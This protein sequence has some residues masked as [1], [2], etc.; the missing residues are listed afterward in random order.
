MEPRWTEEQQNAL[1]DMGTNIIVSAGAGS[2]KTTV[3]TERVIRKLKKG[4][5]INKLL[6]LTFTDAASQ[7]MKERIRSAIKKEES[8]TKQLDLLTTAYICTF[9]SFSLSMVRKYHYLLNIDSDVNIMDNNIN[10]LEIKKIIDD[11][12]NEKYEAKDENFQKLIYQWCVKDDD[13]VKNGILSLYQKID[14]LVEKDEYLDNYFNTQFNKEVLDKKY[15]KFESVIKANIKNFINILDQMI[16]YMKP[17]DYDKYL[18]TRNLMDSIILGYE[19][20]DKFNE[21]IEIPRIYDA[22]EDVKN[23]KKKL[24]TLKKK[25]IS[26]YNDESKEEK[27]NHLLETVDNQKVIINII[28]EL[29]KRLQDFKIKSNTYTFMDI[30]KMAIKIVKNNENIRNEIKYSL[31]E[32]MI[33]EYQDTSDI[34][35]YFINLIA[36]GNV[37]MVGDIKQ[38]I[39]RF[40]NANPYLFQTKY[41]NYG[42]NIGGFKID[43]TNNFRSRKEVVDD[44]NN[45]F[46][47]IMTQEEGGAHYK[48]EHIMKHGNTKYNDIAKEVKH[49]A[50]II[51]YCINEDQKI[52]KEELEA[53]IIA[54]DIKQKID[55]HYQVM[56]KET[57]QSRDIQYDDFVILLGKSK[58]F[59]MYKKVFNY[60]QIPLNIY[61]NEEIKEDYDIKIINNILKLII[62]PNYENFQTEEKYCLTS[63]LRSYL[64]SYTDEKIFDMFYSNNFYDNEVY[65]LISEI[66][67]EKDSLSIS[68]ILELIDD[69]FEII[70]KAN[71]ITNIKK[72]LIHL[73]YLINLSNSLSD[74]GYGLEEYTKYISDVFENDLK[75]EYQNK[76]TEIKNAVK[77]MTIHKS[78]GLEFGICYFPTLAAQFNFDYSKQE[79]AFDNELGIIVPRIDFGKKDTFLKKIYDFKEQTETISEQIRV[80][81]VALTRAKEKI[82]FISREQ[83]KSITMKIKSFEDLLLK[84]FNLN[85]HQYVTEENM[86]YFTKMS[87]EIKK[88][89][90]SLLNNKGKSYTVN[91]IYKERT[92][93]EK[94][95]FSKRINDLIDNSTKELLEFGTKMHESLERIDFKTKDL[96]VLDIDKK[97]YPYILSFINSE[98]LKNV[99]NGKVYKEYQFYDETRNVSGSIDLMI[100]YDNYVDIIDYKLKHVDDEGYLKQL[101]RY[102]EY[103]YNKT[104]KDVNIYLYSIIDKVY[105]KLE[106]NNE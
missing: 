78:K 83:E 73:E 71:R 23:E 103:I 63:I 17:K 106:V 56:D 61:K 37:Y 29:D 36:N 68:E 65:S 66:R 79:F 30:A 85:K 69:R 105:K 47:E 90:I 100:E 60:F 64:F 62:T 4:I 14:L 98:L 76:L 16:Q 102:K 31:N 72:V 6:I 49:N 41:D 77:I 93:I 24:S 42:K 67:K 91:P 25:I 45:I 13:K 70:Q 84:Y 51:T 94:Q 32:I 28:K 89:D 39:Y 44:I 74:L 9:D 75:I 40:R 7:E 55:N 86:D 97:Y 8:L 1:K 3:L 19:T 104:K 81:Y 52:E 10:T 20:I 21:S 26:L 99:N 48:E 88:I 59:E 2:G 95:S 38:S 92:Y 5:D 82:I 35:E 46:S 34:Q 18:E 57:K 27:I 15:Q 33:D 101:S 11:I 53:F 54:N 87:N 50:D 80:L 96:S 58:Y 12:F 22:P 43:L